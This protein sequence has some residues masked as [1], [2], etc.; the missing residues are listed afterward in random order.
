MIGMIMYGCRAHVCIAARVRMH[1]DPLGAA[2]VY[3]LHTQ[4]VN[5]INL[6]CIRHLLIVTGGRIGEAH[7][8]Q[9]SNKSS[10]DT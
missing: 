9:T 8:L 2:I 5:Y 6:N 7:L 4:R 3:S 1:I 10:Q